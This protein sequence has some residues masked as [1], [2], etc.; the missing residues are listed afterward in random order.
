MWATRTLLLCALLCILAS[1]ARG[2]KRT[3]TSRVVYGSDDRKDYYEVSSADQQLGRGTALLLAGNNLFTTSGNRYVPRA[4][5]DAQEWWELCSSDPFSDQPVIEANVYCT[6]FL[7]SANPPW[8]GTAAHCA[9]RMNYA[10]FDFDV[11]QDGARLSF[12]ED[13]IYTVSRIVESG[14]A[15]GGVNDYAILELDR[16]VKNREPYSVVAPQ[17]AVGDS[18]HMIGHPIGLPKKFDRGGKITQVQQDL[19]RA[20]VDSYGGNSGSL[21]MDTSG[22][23]L[24]ILVGGST[25]FV[26]TNSGCEQ[27]NVCP[28]GPG[29]EIGETIV[30][31]CDL[32]ASNSEAANVLRWDCD[33]VDFSTAVGSFSASSNDDGNSSSV[34]VP[35][36]LVML[37]FLA[38]ITM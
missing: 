14:Q 21:V 30:P 6:G 1:E 17:Y 28:G 8:I 20:T 37:A 35:S 13:E 4:T 29:C 36:L 12:N 25:D 5:S 22:R 38:L 18:V 16:E 3:G 23:L 19:I 32:V 15:T 27:T 9:D 10:V 7:I 31:I 2:A 33:G 26:T 34:L 24:G 11:L